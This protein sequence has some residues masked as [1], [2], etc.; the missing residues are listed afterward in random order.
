MFNYYIGINEEM[1]E[2]QVFNMDMED[3]A[4][5]EEEREYYRSLLDDAE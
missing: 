4:K 1:L 2:L 5:E 3:L